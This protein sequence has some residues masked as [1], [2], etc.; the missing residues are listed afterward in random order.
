M[1]IFEVVGRL[2]RDLDFLLLD[3]DQQRVVNSADVVADH[4]VLE[5]PVRGPY[6][7]AQELDEPRRE[8]GLGLDH[9]LEVGF[10]DREHL[11]VAERYG[12]GAPRL[13]V[14]KGHF[15]EDIPLLEHRQEDLLVH[16][17]RYLDLAR[18]DDEELVAR[19][20]FAEYHGIVFV[21]AVHVAR[22]WGVPARLVGG[23]EGFKA[24]HGCVPVRASR[25]VLQES[26]IGVDGIVEHAFFQVVFADIEQVRWVLLDPVL[27]GKVRDGLVEIPEFPAE[28]A[29]DFHRHCRVF[30]DEDAEH[31]LVNGNERYV[32][33]RDGGLDAGV[34]AHAGYHAEKVTGAEYG[35]RFLG[36][37]RGFLSRPDF[38]LADDIEIIGVL[39]AFDNDERVCQI[40]FDFELDRCH[41]SS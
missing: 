16:D 33:E 27:E 4:Q 39:F 9:V 5:L 11:D 30:L 3:L 17:F 18:L 28:E 31:F 35:E 8:L 1:P 26:L 7:F 36:R 6:P 12:R 29:D 38:A 37:R 15:A 10:V 20:V 22:C 19:L 24:L 40:V 14:E 32:F 13:V 34:T 23:L 2:G 41:R 21:G 25:A